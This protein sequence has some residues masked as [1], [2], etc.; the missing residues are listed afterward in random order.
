ME[1]KS[2]R[3]IPEGIEDGTWTGHIRVDGAL[4]QKSCLIFQELLGVLQ[5]S[6]SEKKKFRMVLEYDPE[7]KKAVITSRFLE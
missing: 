5:R 6:F 3:L 1:G 2:E 4:L 7:Q